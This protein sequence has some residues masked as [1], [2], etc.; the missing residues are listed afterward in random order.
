[1][2]MGQASVIGL[3]VITSLHSWGGSGWPQFG[4]NSRHT[5]AVNTS[6]QALQR[7]MA[8]LV[9]DPLASAISADFFGLLPVHYMVPLVGMM[10]IF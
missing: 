2:I 7:V 10:F 8:R 5:G 3:L 9:A 4:Q 1:M 6:G